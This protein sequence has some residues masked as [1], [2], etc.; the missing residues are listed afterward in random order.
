MIFAIDFDGVIHDY[1]NPLMGHRMG[2]PVEGAVKSISGIK[3]RGHRIIVF[4]VRGD[5]VGKK[6][7]AE[8]LNFYHVPFDE[9]TNIKK[10]ADVYIDDK[11]FSFSTWADFFIHFPALVL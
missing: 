6:H 1:K 7:V 10:M 5:D 4:T 2:A 3:K 11:G 9:I 8:W